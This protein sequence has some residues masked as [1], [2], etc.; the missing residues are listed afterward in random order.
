M[1]A[2]TAS[3]PL[4]RAVPLRIGLVLATLLAVAGAVPALMIGLDGSAWDPIVIIIAVLS[5]GVALGTLALVAFAW[6]GRRGPC[7]AIIALQIVSILPALPAFLLPAEETGPGAVIGAV[8]G[9][10]LALTACALIIVGM[11]RAE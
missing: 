10:A 3:P 7:I 11:R 5:G 4:R 6:N 8:I 9:I 2:I 1:T